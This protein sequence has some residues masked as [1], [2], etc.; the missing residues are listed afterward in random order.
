MGHYYSVRKRLNALGVHTVCE[1]ARCPNA[2][3]C[4]GGGTAT[5]LIL[6]EVC[7]RGCRFCA[8]T[9]G[10]PGELSQDEPH[11]IA[12]ATAALALRYVVVT[13]VDRDDLVDG[14]VEHFVLTTRAIRQRVPGVIVELL[15]PDFGADPA[16]AAAVVNSGAQVIGHNL[17][18]TRA[19]T[20]AVRDP[21]C[22][23]DQSL[24]LLRRYRE[25]SDSLLLK[26]SL[27]LGLGEEDEMVLETL[28]D[29]RAAGVDWVT[30]GQY[31]RPSRKHLRVSRYV[32]PE[33]FDELARRAR[34]MGFPL[35]TAGPLVR[36]SYRAAEEHAAHLVARHAEA[37]GQ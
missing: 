33:A 4:W 7:T 6:G 29:L 32:R 19:M 16:A 28:G 23:Y 27:L 12:E 15:T 9:T 3:E 13:S 24:T 35:V 25:L 2:A 18:T 34:E 8:V 22:G 17:E 21:R 20:P 37:A 30:L 26:S 31:L 11:R 36:S 14:G 1:E 10:H 5:F